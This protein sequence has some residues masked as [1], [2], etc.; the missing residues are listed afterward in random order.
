MMSGMLWRVAVLPCR[1]ASAVDA[2]C[3]RES[4]GVSSPVAQA[5][6]VQDGA[7]DA[8]VSRLLRAAGDITGLKLLLLFGQDPMTCDTPLGFA[9]RLAQPPGDVTAALNSLRASG[10]LEASQHAA[11]ADRVSYWL[12]ED[13][14]LFSALGRV[15]EAY[16]GGPDERRG[17]LRAI[18]Y[19]HAAAP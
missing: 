19:P 1:H 16:G 13:S 15:M 8:F 5:S 11:D 4:L 7:V 6:V 3:L 12:S 9:R 10:V 17:L 18:R 14:T 2:Q